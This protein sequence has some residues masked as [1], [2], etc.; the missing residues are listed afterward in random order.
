MWFLNRSDTNRPVENMHKNCLSSQSCHFV[1]NY[2]FT[3][4]LL[5]A[6]VLNVFIVKVKFQITTS[7]AV[8]GVD[9]PISAHLRINVENLHKK[10]S[11]FKQLKFCQNYCLQNN[12]S[13]C[14]CPVCLYCEGKVSNSSSKNCGRS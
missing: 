5:H 11:K 1:K 14:T 4:K 6:N 8:V 12:I 2:F 13:S 7:K 9:M 10:S 3:I